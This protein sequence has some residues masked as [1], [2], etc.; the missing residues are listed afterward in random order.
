MTNTN[1]TTTLRRSDVERVSI[2]LCHSGL[3]NPAAARILGVLKAELTRLGR[4]YDADDPD[5]KNPPT[6]AKIR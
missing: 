4:P 6:A 2:A 3:R 1:D 5:E